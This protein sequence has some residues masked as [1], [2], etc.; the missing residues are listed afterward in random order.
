M[1]IVIIVSLHTELLI[2]TTEVWS[3]IYLDYYIR[4]SIK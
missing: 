4:N 2:A 3:S 1:N